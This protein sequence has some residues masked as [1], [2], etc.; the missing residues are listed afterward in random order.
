MGRPVLK[1]GQRARRQV[2]ATCSHV[3]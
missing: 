2:Y 1:Q 3:R